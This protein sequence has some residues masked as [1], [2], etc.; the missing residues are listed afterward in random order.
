MVA[1]T[2]KNYKKYKTKLLAYAKVVNLKVEFKEESSDGVYIPSRSKIRVDD[3]LEESE[4]IATLLHELGHALDDKLDI[5]AFPKSLERAYK[6]VY[7]G[8]PSKP[9]LNMVVECEKTAWNLGRVIAKKLR[10]KLGK[11]YDHHEAYALK[12]YIN[13]ETR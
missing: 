5:E 1:H 9:Q 7:T 11:W 12:S 3:L 2:L 8:K 13:M 6:Q 10:I 4:E